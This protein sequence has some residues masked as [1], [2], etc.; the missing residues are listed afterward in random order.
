ML[1]NGVVVKILYG[2]K[3]RSKGKGIDS[4]TRDIAAMLEERFSKYRN[5]HMEETN[6]HGKMLLCD[7]RFYLMTSYNFLSF[8]GNYNQAHT[9]GE[10]GIRSENERNIEELREEYFMF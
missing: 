10:T 9:R 1:E 2:I 7:N 6:S 3:E 8:A 5:F 4:E